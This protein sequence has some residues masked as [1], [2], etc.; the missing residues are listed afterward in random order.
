[1]A[2]VAGNGEA[3]DKALS[4]A[5]ARADTLR[6]LHLRDG[7]DTDA[8]MQSL[9]TLENAYAANARVVSTIDQM[10]QTII[11]LSGHEL[12][13]RRRPERPVPYPHDTRIELKAE[14]SRLSQ[15][16]ASGLKSK[17]ATPYA[18]DTAHLLG[19]R[20][21]RQV[22]TTWQSNAGEARTLTATVQTALESL[23]DTAD[24]GADLAA[25]LPDS[26]V[27]TAALAGDAR[28]RFEAAV[29][30]LNTRVSGRTLFAGTATDAAALADA[31]NI[32]SALQSATAGETTAAGMVSAVDAWFD[33]P[34]GGFDSLAY[35]GDS[36]RQGIPIGVGDRVEL[37]VTASDAPIRETLKGLALAA[38]A[39]GPQLAGSV[40]EQR[41]LLETAGS[42]LLGAADGLVETRAALGAVET[43]IE[44]A[45]Q[46]VGGRG[47]RA[48]HG[49]GADHRCRPLRNGDR[50]ADDDEPA[51]NRSTR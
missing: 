28:S 19:L 24:I 16:L 37:D 36:G 3:L 18:G 10:L 39:G 43:R 14:T 42:R 30:T 21:S 26:T 34:G 4:H 13:H 25:T 51:R 35:R 40:P 15:E 1:M 49:R 38:L 2:Q 7:V 23:A 45:D 11:G 44:I 33:T 5:S 6:E 32:L 20:R 46:P 47:H 31:G 41:S 22:L 9:L 27:R 29:A 50:A 17:P 12:L 48:G 8:E